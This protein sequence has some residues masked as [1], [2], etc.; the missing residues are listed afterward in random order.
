MWISTFLD[1]IIDFIIVL[2]IH[3]NQVVM[4]LRKSMLFTLLLFRQAI[5]QN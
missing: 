4:L 1:V 2:G 5:H 3:R